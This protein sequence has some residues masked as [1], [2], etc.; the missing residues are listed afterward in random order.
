MNINEL[1]PKHKAL[2]TKRSNPIVSY[3][4]GRKGW[5]PGAFHWGSTPEGYDF[6]RDCYMARTLSELPPIPVAKEEAA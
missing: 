3:G 5:L 2:A 4:D 1:P 6:W